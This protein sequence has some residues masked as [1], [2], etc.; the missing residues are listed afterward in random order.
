MKKIFLIAFM[1]IATQGFS[2]SFF[3][4]FSY[5]IKAGG[6]YSDFSDTEIETEGL[7]GFHAGIFIKFNFNENWSIQEDFLYS[8]HGAKLK[9]S[10]LS[11]GDKLD[12]NYVAVPIMAKYHSN[13]G[14]YVE[15]GPQVNILLNHTDLLGIDDFKDRIDAG[16]VGGLGYQWRQG[17]LKG[18]GIGARYYYGLTEVGN[19]ATTFKNAVVQLSLSYEF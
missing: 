18:L 19:I 10:F 2:Q 9:N 4:K 16:M 12:L 5:G 17:N 3:D 14:I 7:A 1:A 13:M 11:S 6:N 8:T 15:A